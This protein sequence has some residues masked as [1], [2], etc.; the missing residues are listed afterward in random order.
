MSTDT[1]KRTTAK[2]SDFVSPDNSRRQETKSGKHKNRIQTATKQK[3][4]A[5][6][7]SR[8]MSA[9]ASRRVP[10]NAQRPRQAISPAETMNEP[11]DDGFQFT[12]AHAFVLLG[13]VAGIVLF[14]VF[15]LDL[16][17]EIP[18]D[19]ASISYDIANVAGG[20]TLI[21]LSWNCQ[22]DLK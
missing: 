13:Y 17:V 20:L 22:R 7:E 16:L 5:T 6:H 10:Q 18:F 9:K 4:S 19:R 3:A 1:A 14:V 21:Y 2:R 8:R 12:V 11:V 15:G